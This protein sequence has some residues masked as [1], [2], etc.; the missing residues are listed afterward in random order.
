VHH[1]AELIEEQDNH[2]E[3]S[4]STKHSKD[5]KPVEPKD[6]LRA[7]MLR[8]ANKAKVSRYV[9]GKR[10]LT[11]KIRSQAMRD[12]SERL[13]ALLHH[14]DSKD[15]DGMPSKKSAFRRRLETSFNSDDDNN[16]KPVALED[17]A[18]F[19]IDDDICITICNV[20]EGILIFL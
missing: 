3:K 7:S 17:L 11:Y 15:K 14:T 5:E 19:V 12:S 10:C 1:F 18:P 16:D 8:A 13:V 9:V 4:K 2:K 20:H 6:A